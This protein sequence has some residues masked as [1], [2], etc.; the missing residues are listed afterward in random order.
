MRRIRSNRGLHG[1][2]NC[3]DRTGR[4]AGPRWHGD[5]GTLGPARFEPD[6]AGPELESV[7]V[8]AQ[9]RRERI[10][11]E[12][13]EFVVSVVGTAQ[14]ESLERWKVPVCNVTVGLTDAQADFVEKRVAQIAQDAAPR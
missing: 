9:R 1:H 8:E 2:E 10:D 3:A 7:T 14:V 5:F 4:H 12:V 6:A 13:S 11:Q